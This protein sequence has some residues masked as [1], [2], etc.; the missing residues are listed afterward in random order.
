MSDRYNAG[1]FEWITIASSRDQAELC[2]DLTDVFIAKTCPECGWVDG[3]QRFEEISGEPGNREC[4]RCGFRFSLTD[5]I[6]DFFAKEQIRIPPVRSEK[7]VDNLK[8]FYRG[9]KDNDPRIFNLRM[10]AERFCLRKGF[11]ELLS[12]CTAK[13][14]RLEHQVNTAIAVLKR[15]RGRALL[16]DEVGMGKTVEAGIIIKE[17]LVRG[18]A[19]NVLV[20]VP[21][22]LTSQWQ[23]EMKY[24]FNEHFKVFK[25]HTLDEDDCRLIASYDLAKNR[26]CLQSRYWDVLVLDEVHRLKSR[27][28]KLSK[29]VRQIRSRN[30]IGISATPVMNSLCELYSLL[31]LIKPGKVGTIRAFKRTFVSRNNPRKVRPGRE[32]ALKDELSEIMI[33]N[34]RD[35]CKMKFKKRRAGIF[36]IEPKSDE[37]DLYEHVTNYVKEEFKKEIL[38]KTGRNVHMLSLI[39]LQRELMSTHAAVQKT[40][41][42]IA[43]RKGYPESTR[44]RLIGFAEMAAAIKTPSKIRALREIL[45]NFHGNRFIVFTEFIKS[46]ECIMEHVERWGFSAFS[47]S[48]KMSS[49]QRTHVLKAFRKTPA[50]ILVSTETG[51]VGLNLQ[52]CH[53]LVNYDL[54]WNPLRIEQRIGRLDRIGQENEVYV[55]N[56][57]CQHTIEEYV[58]DILAKKLRMFEM[59]IGEC[60]AVL[61]HMEQGKSFE[62]MIVDVWMNISSKKDEAEVFAKLAARAEKARELYNKNRQASS[63]L[64]LIGRCA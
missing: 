4:F 36:Y 42:K 44:K 61:G 48:G 9:R 54:P 34:R 31:D 56:L 41:L 22:G 30:I 18:I 2:E 51:G 58:V 14:D 55:Y 23:E 39:I 47:L 49:K 7:L 37:L 27:S 17:L 52:F 26:E 29:F 50:S 3:D 24:K 60:G 53:H 19:K 28:T 6:N 33:R 15:F 32:A 5:E 45:A 64:D 59:V 63:V 8:Y 12:L 16:A 1:R 21:A 62:Q 38:K 10:Q 25:K 46:L 43:H 13:I 35:K 57:V 40:L 20:L 11:D